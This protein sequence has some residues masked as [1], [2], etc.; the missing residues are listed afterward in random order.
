MKLSL[1]GC[2]IDLLGVELRSI[3]PV[4]KAIK[5]GVNRALRD[6][7]ESRVVPNTLLGGGLT[8]GGTVLGGTSPTKILKP[9]P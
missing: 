8:Q 9:K 5:Y 1:A 7:Q 3:R 2:K 6:R 4:V